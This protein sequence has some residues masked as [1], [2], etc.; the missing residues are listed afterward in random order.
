MPAFQSIRESIETEPTH[1]SETSLVSCSTCFNCQSR[2]GPCTNAQPIY[3]YPN[4]NQAPLSSAPLL[5]AHCAPSQIPAGFETIIEQYLRSVL[6][7]ES[8]LSSPQSVSSQLPETASS[9][10]WTPNTDPQL[11]PLNAMVRDKKMNTSSS[12]KSILPDPR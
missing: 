3:S 11:P 9:T 1:A 8:F 6:K 2:A 7:P 5:P 12:K 10:Y 4:A